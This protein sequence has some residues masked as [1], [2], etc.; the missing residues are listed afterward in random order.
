MRIS[1]IE[2]LHQMTRIFASR[3]NKLSWLLQQLRFQNIFMLIH[4]F[5]E[6]L[7]NLIEK[8]FNC[9]SFV[10]VVKREALNTFYFFLHKS[11]S[12][13]SSAYLS[14]SSH[15]TRFN[16][17]SVSVLGESPAL[18][19]KWLTV[20][21][22]KQRKKLSKLREKNLNFQRLEVRFKKVERKEIP[23]NWKY[24]NREKQPERKTTSISVALVFAGDGCKLKTVS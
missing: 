4:Q 6:M 23:R 19:I 2:Q 8:L 21:F 24:L 1:I 17:C 3:H 14:L 12:V 20:W 13:F 5:Q 22:C 15:E 11:A 10:T 9:S 16:Y 7:W 18:G